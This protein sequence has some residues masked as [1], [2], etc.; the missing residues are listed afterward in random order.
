M[1]GHFARA[2]CSVALLSWELILPYWF[3]LGVLSSLSTCALM[4]RPLSVSIFIPYSV[5]WVKVARL[6]WWL[7]VAT[8]SQHS[9]SL[10]RLVWFPGICSISS[11]TFLLFL[12]HLCSIIVI[13]LTIF[14]FIWLSSSRHIYKITCLFRGYRITSLVPSPIRWRKRSITRNPHWNK[15]GM[16]CC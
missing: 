16:V 6:P 3:V 9:H 8:L 11:I 12:T 10:R 1:G 5:L 14:D 13:F 2:G 4:N 15:Q 7:Y